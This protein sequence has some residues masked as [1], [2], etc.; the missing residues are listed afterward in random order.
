M[1]ALTWLIVLLVTSALP[2]AV[3]AQPTVDT[4]AVHNYSGLAYLDFSG[5][6]PTTCPP[7][8]NSTQVTQGQPI[9]VEIL[10]PGVA[11]E[12]AF[13][14]YTL[15]ATLGLLQPGAHQVSVVWR[16]EPPPTVPRVLAT[17][18][19]QWPEGSTPLIASVPTRYPASIALLI[20]LIGGVG[21]WL[22]RRELS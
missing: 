12:F 10:P 2:R 11:C 6:W 17:L 5:W 8:G 9:T 18:T 4:W 22:G 15:T 7:G 19:I 3:N 16:S 1:R 20:A 14:P 13:S 21:L